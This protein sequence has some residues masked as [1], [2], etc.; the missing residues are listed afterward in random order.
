M[1][2]AYKIPLLESLKWSFQWAVA[3]VLRHQKVTAAYA[4]GG[5][6]AGLL[7][8]SV[9]GGLALLAYSLACIPLALLT[10]AEVLRGPSALDAQTLGEGPGRM[11]G[12]FLDTVL[13]GL[14]AVLGALLPLFALGGLAL[15]STSAALGDG[16]ELVLILLI[17]V[18]VAV[19]AARPSLR[20]PSR[21]LGDPISWS[22]AW[23]LGEGNTLALVLGPFLISVPILVVERVIL[24]VFG[25]TLGELASMVLLPAQ[26]VLTCAF[27]SVAYGQLRRAR[28][29]L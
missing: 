20:L 25:V 14:A 15:S 11:I 22:Q 16:L 3:V 12:Y 5:I 28:P 17:M 9:L 21:V 13:I 23:R 24:W 18:F 26:V 2:S 29:E 10:H 6:V 8:S 27:L 1:D 19:I 7:G 4:A